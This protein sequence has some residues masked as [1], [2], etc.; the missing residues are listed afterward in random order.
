MGVHG[1][2][3]GA[4]PAWRGLEAGRSTPTPSPS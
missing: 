1:P 2:A 3:R 4:W